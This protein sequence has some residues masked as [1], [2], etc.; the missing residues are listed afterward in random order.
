MDVLRVLDRQLMQ[1]EGVLHLRQLLLSGLEEP[2]PHEAALGAPGRRLFQRHR[3][4]IAP[5]AVLVVS[6]V[7]DHLGLLV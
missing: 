5:V 3:A 2:Q 1:P 7:D 4:L 6:T